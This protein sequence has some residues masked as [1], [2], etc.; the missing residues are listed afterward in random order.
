MVAG[1]LVKFSF[2]PDIEGENVIARLE[3]P[4][5]TTADQT[6]AIRREVRLR[7]RNALCRVLAAG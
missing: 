6:E 1:G 3:M 2:F 5:G 4:E 7:Q